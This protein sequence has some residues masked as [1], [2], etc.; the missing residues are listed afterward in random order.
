MYKATNTSPGTSAPMNM[1]PALVET[2][3]N[4]DGMENSPVASLY[5]AL[6]VALA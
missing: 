4:S 3:S 5:S 1:S 6:R 2:T